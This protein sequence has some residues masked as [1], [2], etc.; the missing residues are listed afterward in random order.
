M[1]LTDAQNFQISQYLRFY[2][3]VWEIVDI[4]LIY[5]SNIILAYLCMCVHVHLCE[6]TYLCM[7]RLTSWHR[8]LSQ[9]LFILNIASHL[10]KPR[11]CC[12]GYSGWSACF[13]GSV[14]ASHHWVSCRAIS[15]YVDSR[16][17]NYIFMLAGQPLYPLNHIP[18]PTSFFWCWN[19]RD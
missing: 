12:L 5:N 6:H 13:G 7:H 15:F 18:N 10:D 9:K 14:F 17:T 1:C 3:F 2:V 8:C 11:A 19:A 4:Y 16:D